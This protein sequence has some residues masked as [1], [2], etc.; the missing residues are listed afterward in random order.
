MTNLKRTLATLLL[1]SAALTLPA[2]QK[3]DL[4]SHL[5]LMQ[6]RNRNLPVYSSRLRDFAPRP[7]ATHTMAM[8]EIKNEAA[9][10]SLRAQGGEVLKRRGD[11]AIVTLPLAQVEQVAALKAVKRIEL[12]R[13]VYQK[14]NLVREVVGVDNI[15]QGIDL[16]QAYTGKG[17]VT[18]IVDSGID[19]N[20]INFLND[21]GST[22]FGY[23]SKIYQSNAS[24]T[25]YV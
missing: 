12:P 1:T 10:D 11:I 8:V 16:P 2:Q 15:H 4:L 21:D 23:I 5:A 24:K 14:M 20:H 3:L 9:L 25:G 18:G 6:Q 7:S 19:P 22:R 13:R 17:V